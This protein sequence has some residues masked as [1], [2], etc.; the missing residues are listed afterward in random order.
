MPKYLLD[1]KYSLQG[2][3]AVK[4]HGGSARVAAATELVESLGGKLD[5]F[6][7]AFGETDAYVIAD[8]PD[9][10]SA[11]SAAQTVSAGG[12]ATVRTVVLLTA[13]EIDAAAS[14]TSTYRPPGS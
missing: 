4:A 10:A 7:F 14:K 5:S 8:L 2:I 13:A 12:G 11:A 1:V 6:Y 9:N 3:R